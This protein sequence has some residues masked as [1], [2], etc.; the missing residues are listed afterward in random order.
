MRWQAGF[1]EE[2]EGLVRWPHH[3]SSI[4]VGPR[5]GGLIPALV[6]SSVRW[7]S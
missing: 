6:P 7:L 5:V 2:G 4:I 1:L 3:C